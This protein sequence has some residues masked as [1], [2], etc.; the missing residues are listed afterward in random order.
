MKPRLIIIVSFLLWPALALSQPLS[1]DSCKALAL[2]NQAAMR[3][4]RLDL[5]AARQTKAEAFTHHFPTLSLSAAA[6]RASNNLVDI[7][8]SSGDSRVSVET[9]IAGQSTD[10]RIAQL[11]EL[12]DR[13]GINININGILQEMVSQFDYTARIQM[14]DRG[15]TAGA[16]ATWPIYAG[17]RISRGNELAALGVDVAA[18]QLTMAEQQTLIGAEQRYWLVAS[19]LE[20]ERALAEA[21]A[22]LDTLRRDAEAASAAGVIGR[23]DL[24]KVKLRQSELAAQK[25]QLANGLQ[26][27]N[28][29]L[30]QYVG[31]EYTDSLKLTDSLDGH[32]PLPLMADTGGYAAMA[33]QRPE[34]QLLHHA[35]TAEHLR[36]RM[37]LGEALP[38]LLIGATYG[39]SNIMGD[40]YTARGIVFATAQVPLT[41]WW[42]TAHKARRQH[43]ELEK[44]AWRNIDLRQ[45]LALQTR[46][47][48]NEMT[49]AYAFI[50]VKRQALADADD[51]LQQL[52]AYYSAGMASASEYLEAQALR[53]Q[54]AASLAEQLVDY[55]LK[56]LQCSLMLR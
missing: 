39:A 14:I 22:L 7:T 6:F 20:K 36:Y 44:A 13:Y 3:V 23:N 55:R 50:D 29:A 30:C 15:T 4:A 18:L 17:G 25:V 53:Q 51:N 2:R 43:I 40:D 31:M 35:V 11:Q 33:E 1:L 21:E 5:E 19:L 27:A 41:A 52:K 34:T 9:S 10:S 54:A 8:T 28:L 38:Q 47:A 48:W 32:L 37:T 45:Q 46:Q 49:E 56:R 16:V 12:I 42:G 26:L 24:L